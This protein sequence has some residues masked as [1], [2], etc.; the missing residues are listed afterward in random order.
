MGYD[1][2]K[3]RKRARRVG[4]QHRVL[5]AADAVT[6]LRALFPT[7]PHPPPLVTSCLAHALD[8]KDPIFESLREDYDGF[9][10]WFV[11]CCRQQRQV[12]TISGSNG[13]GGI[14]IV[15]TQTPSHYGISGKTLKLCTFKISRSSRGNRYGELMLKTLFDYLWSNGYQNVFVEVFDK[16]ADLIE[17]LSDF[18]FVEVAKN[19]RGELVLSKELVVPREHQLNA[20]EFN[21]RYG[22]RNF[23]VD[24]A[25][26]LAIPIQPRYHSLLFPEAEHN[27]LK[28]PYESHPF[29][30]SIRKAYLSH[31]RLR[32]VEPGSVLLFYR[33][34]DLK[35]VKV[36]G[37]AEEK[38]TS[39]DADAIA[40]FV[41]RRTVYSYE[42]IQGMVKKGPVLAVLF[43]LARILEAPWSLDQIKRSGILK[44]PPQSFVRIPEDKKQWIAEQ[45]QA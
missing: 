2:S 44:G 29:G 10:E 32:R 13:Y 42:D 30:N 14:C 31:S 11:K 15:D 6:T 22:P 24:E 26:A 43:R 41:G 38:L 39:S 36:I 28:L 25:S 1:D 9:D 5:S 7:A 45:L 8:R 34:G 37:V 27:Q 16:H 40:R 12:W 18:G 4:L 23:L 33:S 20:L 35:G 21:V 19:E 17:L 3:L